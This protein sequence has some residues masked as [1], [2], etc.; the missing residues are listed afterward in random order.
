MPGARD[1]KSKTKKISP[2]VTVATLAAVTTI[3][4]FIL[5]KT[6]AKYLTP[7][8]LFGLTGATASV[9]TFGYLE[10]FLPVLRARRR[11]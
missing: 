11:E 6:V 10:M 2:I 1:P 4:W 9:L 8:E 7:T 3:L 5:G